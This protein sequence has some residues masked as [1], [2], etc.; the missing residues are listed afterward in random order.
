MA[1]V[2]AVQRRI[3]TLRNLDKGNSAAQRLA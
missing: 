1:R 2:P 3:Q